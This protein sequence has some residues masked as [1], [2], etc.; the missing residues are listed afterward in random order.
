MIYSNSNKIL[1]IAIPKTGTRSVYKYFE[2]F[3]D[4]RIYQ[5][6]AKVIP[7]FDDY[8]K[9]T[10]VRN[11]YDRLV[12]AWWSTCKRGND[13]YGY[14]K[15][16]KTNGDV[17][18]ND[19]CRNLKKLVNTIRVPHLHL[20]T[21]WLE[22]N[23]INKIIRYENLNNEWLDLP[24]NVNKKP[25]PHINATTKKDL[26]NPLNSRG[27]IVREDYTKYLNEENIHHINNFY[28]KDFELLKYEFRNK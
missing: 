23:S 9:F 8:Y 20:Q 7:G 16:I 3:K 4:S 18:F 21:D 14:K 22:K 28:S 19:V 6:H 10:I 25:L 17:D 5:D 26:N 24:F 11:P 13:R 12:S 1:F 27:N 2:R 15:V